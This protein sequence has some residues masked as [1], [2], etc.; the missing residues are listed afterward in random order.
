MLSQG[1][2]ST[3]GLLWFN[4]LKEHPI[5]EQQEPTLKGLI[6]RALVFQGGCKIEMMVPQEVM[7]PGKM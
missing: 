6:H 5:K 7:H 2:S 3:P 1:L 4:S